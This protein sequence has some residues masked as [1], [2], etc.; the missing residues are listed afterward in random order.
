MR[1]RALVPGLNVNLE[2]TFPYNERLLLMLVL[3]L[4]RTASV[5]ANAERVNLRF[6]SAGTAASALK[7][8]GGEELPVNIHVGVYDD[9]EDTEGDVNIIINPV[10]ARG[11]P[12]LAE[13]ER[14]V[15]RAPD[16]IWILLNPDFSA[17]RSA[18]G[19]RDQSR[20]KEFI[21]KF[22]DV[23]YFRNL[24]IISR[25]TLVPVEKG[26]MMFCYGEK[27]STY[28]LIDG[29]YKQAGSFSQE[30]SAAEISN[31]VQS[32][33][34]ANTVYEKEEVDDSE[35]LAK[36]GGF[37]AVVFLLYAGLRALEYYFTQQVLF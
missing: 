4:A 10:A 30:P 35:Y 37:G 11:N 17:D 31:A 22:A 28:S 6:K 34:E 8:Y 36:V 15:N 23:F 33:I 25:P 20:R 14:S 32:G 18:L 7:T 26:A 27:W 2:D 13:I 21:D 3:S 1:V 19:M 9:P 5:T 12:V 24:F 16:Q 29:E